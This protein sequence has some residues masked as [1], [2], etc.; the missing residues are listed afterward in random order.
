[1]DKKEPKFCSLLKHVDRRRTYV[2]SFDQ[3]T[4]FHVYARIKSFPT[5][6]DPSDKKS[7]LILPFRDSKE[8]RQGTRIAL[9]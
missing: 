4:P 2:P 8:R 3:S 6:R 1:M 5:I 7:L 9:G